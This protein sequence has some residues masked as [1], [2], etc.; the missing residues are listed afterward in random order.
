MSKE[1]DSHRLICEA[2]SILQA[3]VLA[4]DSVLNADALWHKAHMPLP[5]LECAI[6]LLIEALDGV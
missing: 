6:S 4:S 1:V 5:A 2:I 3:Q